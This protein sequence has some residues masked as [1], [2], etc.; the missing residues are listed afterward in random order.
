MKN[1]I[2]HRKSLHDAARKNSVA[3]ASPSAARRTSVAAAVSL[4]CTAASV[5][6]SAQDAGIEEVIVTATR[7]AQST[8]DVP[9]NIS[10]VSGETLTDAGVSDIAELV[11]FIPGIVYADIGGRNAGMNSQIIL[12]G[13][14]GDPVGSNGIVPSIAPS[15]VSTYIGE[16]PIFVDVKLADLERVEVLRGPQGTIYGANSLGGTIRFLPHKPSVEKTDA[17]VRTSIGSTA[18]ARDLNYDVDAMLNVPIGGKVAFRI[19][20][21]YEDMAGVVDMTNIP[22][23][24]APDN[25]AG[26]GV[27]ALA[28][29]SD[30]FGSPYAVD[31][32]HADTDFAKTWYA[33]GSLLWNATE[34]TEI[35][36]RYFHQDD[37]I[38]GQTA[39]VFGGSA[40]RINTRPDIEPLQ[41][42]VDILSLDT[43]VDL[44]F[45]SLTSA[46]SY[47]ENKSQ[48]ASSVT[49]LIE[50]LSA[51]YGG[52]PRI[53][54]PQ[55]M[56]T[57][58]SSFSEEIR[59][60]SKSAGPWNWLVGGFYLTHDQNAS[61]EE[62]I[63]GFKAWSELPHPTAESY[64]GAGAS[65]ADLLEAR[66]QGR[67]ADKPNAFFFDR[68]VAVK[69][70]ALFGEVGY[71]LSDAWQMTFGARV[72]WNDFEQSLI[73]GLPYCGAFCAADGADPLGT[74]TGQIKDNI[75]DQIFKFN[76][77]Y[78]IRD[79]TMMYFTWAQGFRRGG[80]NAFPLE[81]ANFGESPDL[82]PFKADTATNWEI[83]VK[84][85]A[86]KNRIQY[87][88][89]AYFIDWQDPQINTFTTPG[90]F[91][92]V[93]NGK[94]A[95]SK[96]I[97]V[98]LRT[99]IT[100]RLGLTFG[101]GYTDAKLT[102]A[103]SVEAINGM[104]GDAL[105]GVP[106]N[107][108]TLALDY[109]R[110]LQSGA[111]ILLHIDGF[112]R[113]KVSTALNPSVANYAELDSQSIWNASLVWDV[114]TWQVGIFGKNLTDEDGI[115]GI[116]T[117][118]QVPSTALEFI[119]RP[120]TLGVQFNY[121]FR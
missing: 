60:V 102:K 34:Q 90:G 63:P 112:Y 68:K 12:R 5:V 66:G 87:S 113:S 13:L 6:A 23:F 14:R 101:Y 44:G 20:A 7:R 8:Q 94:S 52:F 91:S 85:S 1:V 89:A 2:R 47:W 30:P 97:E 37:D 93:A 58:I 95:E 96:G 36:L 77:S 78:D 4:A 65:W 32:K 18:D 75:H 22:V 111:D 26:F 117:Q 3:I 53:T 71:Q 88:V 51:Y 86:A 105:P 114:H 116:Y 46:T 100:D 99:R 121:F 103:F 21:G 38:G 28:D 27:P 106:K 55:A 72:F 40:N 61:G 84:G 107:Q 118:S 15:T 79:D 39:Q 48:S 56:R 104:N 43:T 76:T 73:T 16:T 25:P 98:E 74:A 80:G 67:P 64:L 33:R 54:S 17:S 31:A 109:A 108:V 50:V 59:L 19:A 69:D 81:P 11:R 35:L 24:E 29:P 41:R 10:A 119:T 70:T 115:S 49:G 57:D 45:A 9:Y 83:G 120:R 42:Q 62:Y 110:P 82:I 92:I